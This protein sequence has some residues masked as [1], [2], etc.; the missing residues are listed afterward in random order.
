M[1]EQC[2][3]MPRFTRCGQGRGRGEERVCHERLGH[4]GRRAAAQLMWAGEAVG[5]RGRRDRWQGAPSRD[6]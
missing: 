5:G 1:R 6:R 3:I 4:L 2:G